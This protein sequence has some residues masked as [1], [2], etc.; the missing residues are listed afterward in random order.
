MNTSDIY[1]HTQNTQ[2]PTHDAYIKSKTPIITKD[3][4]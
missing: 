1:K 2:T 3:I 4:V